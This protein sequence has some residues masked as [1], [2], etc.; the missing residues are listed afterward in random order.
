LTIS[1]G[2]FLEIFRTL[3]E[4]GVGLRVEGKYEVNQ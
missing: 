2:K 1:P 3:R 4:K